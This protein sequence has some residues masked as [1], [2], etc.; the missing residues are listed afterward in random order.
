MTMPPEQ[1]TSKHR[2]TAQEAARAAQ[3]T[4]A[5]IEKLRAA[6]QAAADS[7]KFTEWLT[8]HA[9]RLEKLTRKAQHLADA[10]TEACMNAGHLDGEHL[11]EVTVTACRARD[12]LYR[13]YFSITA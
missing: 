2:A 11:V 10:A 3:E 9:Q 13:V 7:E 1:Q 12:D 8:R 5:E 4:L 6:A